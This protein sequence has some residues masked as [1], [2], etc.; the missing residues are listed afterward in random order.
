[1]QECF[2]LR[3]GSSVRDFLEADRPSKPRRKSELDFRTGKKGQTLHSLPP[4]SKDEHA[5]YGKWRMEAFTHVWS[6]IE[7]AIKVHYL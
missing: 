7:T 5:L 4:F 6:R 1:M 3:R 2:V